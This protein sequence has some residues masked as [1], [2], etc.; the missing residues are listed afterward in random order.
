MPVPL[1]SLGTPSGVAETD[2]AGREGARVRRTVLPG[3]A[4]VLTEAVP[5]LRSA[6]LGAWVGV[7]SRDEADHQ[8]GSTHFLEH[9]LFKGT[10]RRSAMDIAAAFD[11]VGGDANA[12]T[13]KENTS[14]YARVLDTDLPVAVDVTLDMVT[15]ASLRAEDVD[16]ERGVILEELAAA[17]DDDDDVAHE[18]FSLLVHGDTPLGR[19]IGGTPADIEAATRD[20]VEAHYR[21]HY[22][23]EGLVVTAA[24]G[25]EHDAVC[26]LVEQALARAGWPAGADAVPLPRRTGG[27][28]GEPLPST[29]RPGGVLTLERDTEQ[30]HVLLGG[31]GL[32]ATD[33]RRWVLGVLVAVLGGGM[34]SRLFQEVRERRGLAYS[35]YAFDAGYSDDGLFGLY[36]GC[37]PSRVPQ[38]TEL[39]AEQWA[40]L[41]RDGLGEDELRRGKGQLSGSL[42]LG[43]EDSGARM[44]RLARAELV[45]G[46]FTGVDES[47][48]RIAAVTTDDVVALAG[49]L[50][51]APR[52]L[53]VLGPFD[54]DPVPVAP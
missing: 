33:E 38:V 42:V 19:P 51:A 32:T 34:S 16:G 1:A 22:V 12:S 27:P 39:L 48:A 18:R 28:A 47:L 54:D 41:A 37:T 14:Y 17:E 46:R 2:A 4:V 7:G 20:A 6:T 8:R 21:R 52:S 36:A 11:E 31:P 45:H 3:G 26:A 10:G 9:L 5:G 24:G 23:P 30:A 25:L 44:T 50:L 13:G 53:L 40:L 49:E 43:M 35:T 29:L 15:S